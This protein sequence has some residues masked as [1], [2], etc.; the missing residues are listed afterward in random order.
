MDTGNRLTDPISKKGVIIVNKKLLKD[1][2]N[3]RSPVYVIYKTIKESGLMKCFKP[4]YILFNNY[5]I[6]DYLIGESITSF[7]DGVD[8]LLNIKLMEDNY[9]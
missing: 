5:K 1:V 4:S 3:I 8:C 7:S 9:V 6:K 2:Y